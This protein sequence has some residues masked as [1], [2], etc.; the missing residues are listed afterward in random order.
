M[1]STTTASTGKRAM[2]AIALAAIAMLA[3]ASAGATQPQTTTAA[4]QGATHVLG[5]SALL[6]ASIDPGGQ[7]TSYYFLY[8][9]T[10]AYGSQIGPFSIGDGTVRIPVGHTISHLT[11]GVTYHYRVL[12]VPSADPP[13]Q[14]VPTVVCATPSVVICGRDAWFTTRSIPLVV[15]LEK[16]PPE[17]YGSP[18]V[19]SGTLTGT[20][21]AGQPIALQA[22]PFP[23]LEAFSSIGVPAVTNTSGDFSF[24]VA[25]LSANTQLRASTLTPL[26]IFSPFITIRV[27]PRIILHVHSSG[28]PG[29]V[30]LYGT[31]TPATNGALVN[32]Q[33]QKAV[34]PG[35]SEVTERWETQFTTKAR[36]AGAKSSR[37]SMVVKLRYGGRYQAYVRLRGG[38]LSSGASV[39]TI[40][41]HA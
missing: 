27:S 25:N 12:A 13:E 18:F 15:T 22:S 1:S 38:P 23:Y 20:G 2:T 24:R 4:T 39:N 31:I 3:P 33:V 29:L 41:I 5:T 21:N 32:L 35:P 37:F 10:T 17:T 40:I 26:P 28:V 9:T 11:P 16:A 30:R 7:A 19:V 14:F 6:T 8:G 34:R 36:K